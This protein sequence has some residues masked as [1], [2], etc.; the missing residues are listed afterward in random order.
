[1]R[2]DQK[3]YYICWFWT[4]TDMPVGENDF[5]RGPKRIFYVLVVDE[6]GYDLKSEQQRVGP[7][8]PLSL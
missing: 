4:K 1:M 2:V 3:G 8:R 6:E 5:V 7:F